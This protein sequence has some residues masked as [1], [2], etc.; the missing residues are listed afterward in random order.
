MPPYSAIG[1]KRKVRESR[2][3]IRQR[4]DFLIAGW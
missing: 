4:N 3:Q 2:P 1:Q